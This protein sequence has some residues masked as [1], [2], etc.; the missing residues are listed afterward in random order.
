MSKGKKL[1]YSYREKD[2]N[3]PVSDNDGAEN[4]T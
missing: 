2:R 3:V 1:K 4:I